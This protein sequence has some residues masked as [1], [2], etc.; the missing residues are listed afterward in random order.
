MRSSLNFAWCLALTMA[1]LVLQPAASASP[2]PDTSRTL[3]GYRAVGGE[4]SAAG[5]F[6]VPTISCV[7]HRASLITGIAALDDEL[8]RLDGFG[9][10]SRC[11][12]AG[13]QT[14]IVRWDPDGLRPIDELPVDAGDR[15]KFVRVYDEF[16]VR[17]EQRIRN[18]TQGWH[19]RLVTVDAERTAAITEIGDWRA[20]PAATRNVPR[21]NPHCVTRARVDGTSLA[22]SAHARVDMVT[23]AGKVLITAS[24]VRPEGGFRLRRV[25][26]HPS[27]G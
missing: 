8:H 13:P 18:L 26:Q 5:T 27:S 24:R 17:L 23:A 25:V 4:A 21:F 19:V 1:T 14:R 16:E 2:A 12:P 6:V 9:V 7:R 15:I 10:Q 20:R 3:G 11:T 22:G